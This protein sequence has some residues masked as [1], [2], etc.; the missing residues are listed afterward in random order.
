MTGVGVVHISPMGRRES[1]TS[2]EGFFEF[3]LP[4]LRELG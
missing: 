3:Y 1:A 2:A 4:R